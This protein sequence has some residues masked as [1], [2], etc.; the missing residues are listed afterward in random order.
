LTIQINVFFCKKK[1]IFLASITG[2]STHTHTQHNTTKQN[3]TKS[4][5][6]RN[7][8]KTALLSPT[9]TSTPSLRRGSHRTGVSLLR[10]LG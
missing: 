6:K 3:R 7:N 2:I 1:I 5:N 10:G 8:R 4:K 9:H